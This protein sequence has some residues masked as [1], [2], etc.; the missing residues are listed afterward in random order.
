MTE[1][2]KEYDFRL[3]EYAQLLDIRAD[4]IKVRCVVIG[5]ISNDTRGITFL[6]VLNVDRNWNPRC[7]MLLMVQSSTTWSHHHR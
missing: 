5:K 6:F 4:R 3:Q 1:D 2:K 7:E